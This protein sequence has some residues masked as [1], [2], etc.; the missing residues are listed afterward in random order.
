M[1]LQVKDA[2]YPVCYNTKRC[3][4]WALFPVDSYPNLLAFVLL[5]VKVLELPWIWFGLTSTPMLPLQ[6]RT[7]RGLSPLPVSP[8]WL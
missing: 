6:P 5:A 7:F 2:L 3:K 8:C 1:L 4:N